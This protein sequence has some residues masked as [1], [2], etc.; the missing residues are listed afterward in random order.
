MVAYSFSKQFVEPSAADALRHTGPL[1][2][3]VLLGTKKQTIRGDRTRHARPPSRARSPGEQ[4]QLYTPMRTKYCRLIGRATCDAVISIQLDF[5]LQMVRTIAGATVTE[6]HAPRSRARS[7]DPLD[8]FARGDGF[9]D[10]DHMR[11]F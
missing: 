1:C 5:R 6:L 10:W 4:M 3:P 7:P 2:G 9:V 11:A 8:E